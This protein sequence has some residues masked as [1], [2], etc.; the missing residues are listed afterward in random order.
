MRCEE[1]PDLLSLFRQVLGATYNIISV[2]SGTGCL[3][4]YID[5]KA[6][7]NQIDVL[8]VDYQ[9]RDLPGDIVAITIRELRG[10]N[11]IYLHLSENQVVLIIV[12]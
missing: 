8:L 10:G 7:G 2:D 5:E 3:S 12:I 4:R 6:K 11:R 1:D 9:L